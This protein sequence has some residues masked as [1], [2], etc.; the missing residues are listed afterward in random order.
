MSGPDWY[1]QRPVAALDDLLSDRGVVERCFTAEDS[2][3][4]RTSLGL[5]ESGALDALSVVAARL[6]LLDGRRMPAGAT[7]VG[8]RWLQ[9]RSLQAEAA[10]AAHC[11]STDS[12]DS[13][14][15]SRVVTQVRLTELRREGDLELADVTFTFL[16]PA[17]AGSKS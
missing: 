10:I 9:H 12:E 13:K 8:I 5:D 4:L 2:A 17:G 7:M 11:E 6:A 16:L 14:G 1:L 15:R 3:L